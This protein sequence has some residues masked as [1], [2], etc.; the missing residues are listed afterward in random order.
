MLGTDDL[1]SLNS[2]ESKAFCDMAEPSATQEQ[3]ESLK[4]L[5]QEDI[6]WVAISKIHMLI[7]MVIIL[8]TL[9]K[10]HERLGL[11]PHYTK[12]INEFL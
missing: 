7:E 1:D 3:R 12:F 2:I 10:F 4:R 11:L 9:S 8:G 5:K 6:A